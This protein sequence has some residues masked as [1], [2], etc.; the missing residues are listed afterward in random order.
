[1]DFV[2]IFFSSTGEVWKR[3]WRLPIS[4]LKEKH[5]T[6]LSYFIILPNLQP[7]LINFSV[8]FTV[9]FLFLFFLTFFFHLLSCCFS[10]FDKKTYMSLLHEYFS[11]KIYSVA[12]LSLLQ[13]Y[14]MTLFFFS[15]FEFCDSVKLL[16]EEIL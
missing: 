13:Y 5:L 1:M 15:F 11:F 16:A 14:R 3:H 2:H 12:S 6:R 9:C 7:T 8:F 4:L 10:T